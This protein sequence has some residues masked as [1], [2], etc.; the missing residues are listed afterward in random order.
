M[1]ISQGKPEFTIIL[2]LWLNFSNGMLGDE[3]EIYEG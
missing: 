3:I 2:L 1:S